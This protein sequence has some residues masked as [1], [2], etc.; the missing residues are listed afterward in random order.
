MRIENSFLHI[1]GVGEKTEKKYWKSGYTHWEDLKDSG[2]LSDKKKRH[3]EKAEKN[4]EVG[5]SLYFK[6]QLPSKSLWRIYRNFSENTCF[7]DIETTGLSPQKHR[8]TTVSFY[9]NGES[10][11]LVRGKNLNRE[12]LEEEFFK[13]EMIV[14]FN[15]KRFDAPFL[16]KNFDLD[17]ETPHVDLMYPCRR[18]NIQ[19]GLKKI[20]KQLGIDRELEDLDGR[21]A[22]KLWKKYEKRGSQEALETLKRYNRYDAENLKQLMDIVA[23]KLDEEI[24]RPHVTRD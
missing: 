13:S 3:L 15:G 7:F 16:E 22:V 8:V 17:I 11:T 19:G 24:Y 9:R 6:H 21:E 1:P 4:L 2:S 5:N 18:L 10:T 14:T 12:N 23:E 20:E